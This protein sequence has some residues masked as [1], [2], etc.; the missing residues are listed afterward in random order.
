ML[1]FRDH[2]PSTRVPYVTI[3]LI[4]LNILIF[5]VSYALQT[6]REINRIFVEYGLIPARFHDGDGYATLISSMFL[7]SGFMHLAGNMLFLWIYG[8]NLEDKLGHLP[9]LGFYLLCGIAAGLAQYAAQPLSGVP[10]VGA[11]GAIAGVMGGYILLFPRARVDVFVF[12]IVFFR[13]FP[14]PAWVTLGF[15]FGAQIFNGINSGAGGGGVAHWAHAGGFVAGFV[16]MLPFWIKF[17]STGFWRR[18]QGHPDHPESR[19][20]RSSVPVVRR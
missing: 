14:L 20:R 8:D 7:H 6:D 5:V 16:L 19:Y 17:G 2:N 3:A 18:T 13:I 12:F 10:M 9:F 4:A 11:S 1:P 15:W